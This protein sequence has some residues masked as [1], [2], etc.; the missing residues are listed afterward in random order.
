MNIR[1]SIKDMLQLTI[2]LTLVALIVLFWSA[3]NQL[4]QARKSISN[5]ERLVHAVFALKDSRFSVVQIQQ[6]LTDVGATRSNEA[7]TEAEASLQDAIASL[8]RLAKIAPELGP[9]AK[10]LQQQVTALHHTGMTMADAYVNQGTEAGNRL[11]K[12]A[13]GFDNASAT[14]ADYLDQLSHSL[15]EQVEA[16]MAATLT[17]THRAEQTLLWGSL[18]IGLFI[19]G[20]MALLYRRTLT[21]LATLQESMQNIASGA[22]DLTV[23]LD[24]TGNDEIARVSRSFNQ[25][26]GNIRTLFEG[27]NQS[28]LELASARIQLTDASHQTLTGMQQLQA[29]TDQVAAA[30]SEMQATVVEVANN[31]ELAAQAAQ[32]SNDHAIEGDSIVNQTTESINHLANGV[33]HAAETLRK[34]EGNVEEIGTILDVIRGIADQTNLLALNA[35]IEAARAGEQGRGFAVVADEVRTLAKRTQE[36]TDQ[37]QQMISQLQNG[38][39]DAASAMQMSRDQALCSTKQ[40]AQAGEALAQITRSVATISSMATQIATAVEQQ[41]SVA[42]DINRNIVNISD[43]A[44]STATN[45]EAS[46]VACNQVGLLSQQLDSQIGQFKIS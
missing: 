27:F 40:A 6:F 44:K 12:G 14:L 45:A 39:K 9:D 22:K 4:A 28:T 32:D 20:V 10:A 15:D 29:E 16:A 25:F 17:A 11:M 26:V 21:P 1:I 46:A 36:S 7:K 35:A 42:E 2:A 3:Q 38:A 41:S 33:E 43:E 5:E 13:G 8:D 31:A 19:V 24:A 18:L 30:M 37:I 34:L 23:T